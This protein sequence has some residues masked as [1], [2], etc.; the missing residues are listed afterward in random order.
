[1]LICELPFMIVRSLKT[2]L[3]AHTHNCTQSLKA[4]LMPGTR[5]KMTPSP[6]HR[7]D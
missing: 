7:A 5:R 2:V 3:I 1:M 6:N 4:P